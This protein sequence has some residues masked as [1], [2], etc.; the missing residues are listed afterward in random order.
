MLIPFWQ[1]PFHAFSEL[2]GSGFLD[3]RCDLVGEPD[4]ATTRAMRTVS[5][6]EISGETHPQVRVASA[7]RRGLLNWVH[8][9]RHA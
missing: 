8:P 1:V 9:I 3:L 2:A 6:S 4:P 5:E 7:A